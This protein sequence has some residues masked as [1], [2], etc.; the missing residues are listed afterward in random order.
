MMNAR[1]FLRYR[2]KNSCEKF[3]ALSERVGM[4]FVRGM[5]TEKGGLLIKLGK[6]CLT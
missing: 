2:I 3:P 4:E 6:T 5:I 1:W